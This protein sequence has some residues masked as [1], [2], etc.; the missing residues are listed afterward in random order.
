MCRVVAL[1]C[2]DRADDAREQFARLKKANP[3][4]KLDHYVGYFKTYSADRAVGAE[5]S[6]GVARLRDALAE[7]NST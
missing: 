4:I 7:G 1:M 2:L 5:L 3:A 6:A